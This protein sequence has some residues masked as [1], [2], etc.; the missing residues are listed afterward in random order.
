MKKL[1]VLLLFILL[2]MEIIFPQNLHLYNELKKGIGFYMNGAQK[3]DKTAV[4]NA[5]KL[6]EKLHK[7]RKNDPLVAVWLGKSCTLKARDALFTKK[8]YWIKRGFK[9]LD[10][11]VKMAPENIFIRLERAINDLYMPS[12]LGRFKSCKK[13]FD[14]LLKSIEK[15]DG[16]DIMKMQGAEF[17]KDKQPTNDF[18]A[19]LKQKICYFAA[20]VALKEKNRKKAEKII[21]KGIAFAPKSYW[22]KALE[23]V[24]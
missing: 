8:I 10:N 7:K 21:K 1:L 19:S 2:S 6:F 20:K 12:F 14:I 11:A 24:M 4:D 13:D 18:I 15:I 9:L 23:K 16:N 22:A 17:Y 3:G 5:I